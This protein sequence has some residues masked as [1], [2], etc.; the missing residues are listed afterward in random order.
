MGSDPSASLN[1]PTR[2]GEHILHRVHAGCLSVEEKGCIECAVCE[3]R[4]RVRSVVEGDDL[5][6]ACKDDIMNPRQCAT[7]NGTD[8]EFLVRLR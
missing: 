6:L 2:S 4:S 7:T 5:I 8:T 1:V 3:D